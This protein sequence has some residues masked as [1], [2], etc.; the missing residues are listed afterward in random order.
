M[1][2]E[3]LY[4]DI[5]SD[6]IRIFFQHLLEC[7]E[8][9][10][11]CDF[12]GSLHFNFGSF[13]DLLFK[14]YTALH[15]DAEKE[16]SYEDKNFIKEEFAVIL[17]KFIIRTFPIYNSIPDIDDCDKSY[18]VMMAQLAP[19]EK[20]AFITCQDIVK[21]L[22]SKYEN[23][24]SQI[25]VP[26]ELIKLALRYFSGTIDIPKKGARERFDHNMNIA[27]EVWAYETYLAITPT[28]SDKANCVLFSGCDL[29]AKFYSEYENIHVSYAT[30]K[31]IWHE[32]KK[33][34]KS[35]NVTDILSI[36]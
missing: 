22:I 35:V 16:L 30:V 23:T 7:P 10:I 27:I 1:N 24:N 8:G 13:E 14:H 29:V 3:K 36:S 28:R 17:H 2:S 11:F 4:C 5:N 26:N 18:I 34:L 33:I 15:N 19:Y 9:K 25:S 6:I 12:L 31:S 21:R 20:Q 32:N